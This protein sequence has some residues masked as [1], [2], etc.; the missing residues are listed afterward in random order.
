MIRC[1]RVLPDRPPR[2]PSATAAAAAASPSAA[3]SRAAM[4]FQELRDDSSLDLG[5]EVERLRL[6]VSLAEAGYALP[7]TAEEADSKGALP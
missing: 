4:K 6:E 1:I 7:P 3:A 2:R 5:K